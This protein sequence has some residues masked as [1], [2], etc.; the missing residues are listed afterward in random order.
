MNSISVKYTLAKIFFCCVLL[1][2]VSCEELTDLSP[3]DNIADIWNCAETG[4]DNITDNF[5]V[6]IVTDNLTSNG[7][8]IYD[9]NHLGDNIA[10][11]ATVSG[12]SI[13]INEP[14]VDGFEIIGS[15]TITSNYEVINLKYSVDDGGG[16]ENY[17]AKLTKP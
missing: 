16:K 13:S 4:T 14:D 15:G 3:R 9:F 12:S 1:I 8:K 10:V 5:L 11:K 7:I 17:T 6:E 2:A